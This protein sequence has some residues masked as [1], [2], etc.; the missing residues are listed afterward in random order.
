MWYQKLDF[1]P[2]HCVKLT[3]LYPLN[4]TNRFIVGSQNSRNVCVGSLCEN[5]FI[6]LELKILKAGS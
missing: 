6:K 3:T 1:N 2:Y 4:I 5:T